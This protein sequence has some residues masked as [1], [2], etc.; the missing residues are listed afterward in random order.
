M[1]SSRALVFLGV[2]L[3][4]SAL[5]IG[6]CLGPEQVDEDY[7]WAE[8]R[9]SAA[10][11]R[12]RAAQ[13]R[14]AAHANGI[15][16]GWLLA[17]I[18]DAETGMSQCH[19]ELTWACEGPYSADC[20]GP[21][22]AGA[23]DGPCSIMQ[24]GLGMFQFDAGTFTQ[25]LAREGDRILS[26]AGNVAAGVDFVTAMVIR[27]VY[28]PGV[29]NRAEA[30]AWMNGVRVGN[31]RWDPWIRTVTHYYNGCT[32]SASCFTSRYGRYRDHTSNV[33]S[34]MGP[35][36]W[37]FAPPMPSLDAAFVGQGTSAATDTTGEA[38]HTICAGAPLDFHFEVRNTGTAAWSDVGD[39]GPGAFGRA[40]R[41]GVASD[42]PDPFVGTAR[43]SINTASSATVAPGASTTFTMRGN[44]PATPGI[45]RTSWR[46][47]DETRAWFGPDM[48]LS[49]RVTSCGADGD[50]D[51]IDSTTDCNDMSAAIYPGATEVCG[52]GVDQNC[53]GSDEA[54]PMG[55]GASSPD[56]GT[57][58]RDGG[59][60]G[61]DA[62]RSRTLGL[63][64]T[65]G[66]SQG[67]ARWSW[68]AL[69]AF[70]PLLR[71]RSARR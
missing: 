23:G 26:I 2:T 14:D 34:E 66:A 62:G 16:Q 5:G 30:I 17:G 28:I 45:V 41:L 19:S 6:A 65:C 21:V 20:A 1:A 40:V 4:L 53:D 8:S 29:A 54:C 18:A 13:I 63:Q 70:A 33:Y 24:G 43:V 39:I 47:V 67:R 36:F 25:T 60:S 59:L 48:W 57:S 58:T 46:L 55:V 69:L 49:F 12:A 61:N 27:S 52:D 9:L 10:A 56:A 37:V 22:V 71:R 44:A 42:T 15:E 11:R 51:G 64:S 32:P 31:D 68:L 50:G 35:D 3:A 38:Q 7:G